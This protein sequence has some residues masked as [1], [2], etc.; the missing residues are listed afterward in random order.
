MSHYHHLSSTGKVEIN[1][2]DESVEWVKEYKL[3]YTIRFL[4][5]ICVLFNWF[6]MLFRNGW[7]KWKMWRNVQWRNDG[8]WDI[9]YDDDNDLRGDSEKNRIKHRNI[10]YTG[11]TYRG[12]WFAIYCFCHCLLRTIRYLCVIFRWI[13]LRQISQK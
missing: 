7:G 8:E 9:S 10:T 5:P 11:V 4:K 2:N 6:F 12:T 13:K 1:F 3:L